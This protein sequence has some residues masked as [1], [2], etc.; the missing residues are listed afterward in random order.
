MALT[1]NKKLNK[2]QYF[3]RYW[4]YSG[5]LD[6]E[7]WEDS[8]LLGVVRGGILSQDGRMRDEGKF[9]KDYNAYVS[10]FNEGQQL[11]QQAAAIPAQQQAKVNTLRAQSADRISKAKTATAKEVKSIQDKAASDVAKINKQ[12]GQKVQRIERAG[13]AASNSLR[14]LGQD[15]PKG[16]TASQTPRASRRRGA[17]SSAA[18]V[19]RGSARTRGT[20]LSI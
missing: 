17:A 9:Y 16:P 10:L 19:A 4:Q 5:V 8:Q 11:Q 20:N 15:S 18:N 13:N 3:D 7:V 6:N 12:T 14:I 2:T 1:W